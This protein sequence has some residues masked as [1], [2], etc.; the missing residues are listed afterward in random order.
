MNIHLLTLP[1]LSLL[2]LYVEAST[3]PAAPIIASEPSKEHPLLETEKPLAWS[4]L[5]PDR[6]RT[7]ISAALEQYM[8]RIHAVENAKTPTY[9]NTFGIL[10]NNFIFKDACYRTEL[11]AR[12]CDSPEQR[13]LSAEIDEKYYQAKKALFQ[14][15]RIWNILKN[16]ATP[17][18]L[19]Q[20]SPERRRAVTELIAEFRDNGADL[21]PERKAQFAANENE[22]I[23]LKRQFIAN[24]SD[25]RAEW[26]FDITDYKKTDT[27]IPDEY[28]RQ[29]NG[30]FYIRHHIA[31]TALMICPDEKMREALW[32]SI[33]AIGKGDRDN[34]AIIR[35]ILAINQQQAELLGYSCHADRAAARCTMKT[36]AEAAE[37]VRNRLQQLRPEYAK[38]MK[39]LQTIKAKDTG[40]PQAE[41]A[42]WDV[43]YYSYCLSCLYYRH[44]EG[45]GKLLTGDLVLRRILDL[46][47]GMYGISFIEKQ[48]VYIKPGSNKK[49][50]VG[51]VEVWHPSVRYFEIIDKATRKH[52]GSFYLDFEFRENKNE[53]TF[54]LP[55]TSCRHTMKTAPCALIASSKG[56][57]ELMYPGGI[58]SLLHELG[59]TLHLILTETRPNYLG[60]NQIPTDFIEFPSTLHAN[61][62]TRRDV[63]IPLLQ[64]ALSRVAYGDYHFVKKH[65]DIQTRFHTLCDSLLDL[66]IHMQGN[67]HASQ[68]LDAAAK[69]ILRGYLYLNSNGDILSEYIPYCQNTFIFEGRYAGLFYTYCLSEELAA[70]ALYRFSAQSMRFRRTVLSKGNSKPSDELYLDFMG[71][72]PRPDAFLKSLGLDYEEDEDEEPSH[73]PSPLKQ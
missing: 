57:K 7:D 47:S 22:L 69:E 51:T 70:D 26:K 71:T 17:D 34:T 2:S 46:L 25:A 5:T 67:R 40:N 38:G 65:Q 10:L 32:R 14:N 50:T 8:D 30:R 18:W 35:R 60:F 24:L 4:Q 39:L 33:C 9:D 12:V 37:Y 58:Q 29:E 3:P 31:H 36:G 15:E 44:L 28:A 62:A 53:G 19:R 11:L 49:A 72:P 6:I 16:M 21:P 27:P 73:T 64:P 45:I 54:I 1:L 20:Q 43:P 68:D 55:V 61:L 56:I 48:T 23:A 13:R 66:E 42:P 41:L 52:L 63:L 59:H